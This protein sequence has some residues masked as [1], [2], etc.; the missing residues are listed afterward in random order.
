MPMLC[1]FCDMGSYICNP[2]SPLSNAFSQETQEKN[3]KSYAI[4]Y[5]DGEY[6]LHVDEMITMTFLY[7]TKTYYWIFIVLAHWNNS[8]R[9][10]R[11][12]HSDTLS[13]FRANQLL[14]FLL[15]AAYFAKKQQIP[16]SLSGL[17]WSGLEL[18]IY[19]TRGEHAN[20][21]GPSQR[22]KISLL[23]SYTSRGFCYNIIDK[24]RLSYLYQM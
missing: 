18:T 9:V 23:G 2:H 16:I 11:S 21:Y 14:P 5:L 24:D 8:L 1:I 22:L 3:E 13:R 7:Q 12:L 15:N 19:H 17:T 4:L 10:D 20:H 6:K